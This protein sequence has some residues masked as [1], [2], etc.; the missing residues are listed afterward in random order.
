MQCLC[1]KNVFVQS[2]P[3]NASLN[4]F[5]SLFKLKYFT[6]YEILQGVHKNLS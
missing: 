5:E 2:L 3:S 6:R 1:L 4:A